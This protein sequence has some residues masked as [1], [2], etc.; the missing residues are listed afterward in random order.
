MADL[1]IVMPCYNEASR[2]NFEYRLNKLYSYML[3]DTDI[4]FELILVN[5]GS[6]DNTLE[7]LEKFAKD[8]GNFVIVD[9]IS[10]D[11]NVGKGY[12]LKQGISH[13][14]GTYTLM[15]DADLNIPL[16]NI[17][18]FYNY[19]QI[20]TLHHLVIGNRTNEYNKSPIRKFLTKSAKICTK[21]LI[22]IKKNGDTQCGFKMFTTDRVQSI[23]KYIK[24]DRWLFDIE[25]IL[26]MQAL[27]EKVRYIDVKSRNELPSTINS[28]EALFTSI[29]E[30]LIILRYKNQTIYKIK[31]RRNKE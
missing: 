21:K 11:K 12:A 13:A 3:D 28:R 31:K 5:D 25:L 4:E 30:L 1:S 15:I 17:Q 8:K 10:Y 7:V 16:K 24:S 22:G 18:K 14:R 2:K 9:V 19:I 6:T 26:Y 20:A 29:K 27:G 23:L